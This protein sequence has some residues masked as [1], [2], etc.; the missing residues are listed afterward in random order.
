MTSFPLLEGWGH[1]TPTFNTKYAI[2]QKREICHAPNMDASYSRLKK[3]DTFAATIETHQE[4]GN[5]G[6]KI[7]GY[8]K[9]N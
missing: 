4:N 9:L 8:K 6:Y 1:V 3:S 2:S 7:F 5:T